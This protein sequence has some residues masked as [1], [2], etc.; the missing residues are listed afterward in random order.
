MS[1]TKICKICRLPKTLDE[2]YTYR[3]RT[4]NIE[5][6]RKICKTCYKLAGEQNNKERRRRERLKQT[7]K[8]V[9]FCGKIKLWTE[10]DNKCTLCR[11]CS[12]KG[13]LSQWIF[14]I[15]NRSKKKNWN[16][17]IDTNFIQELFNKQGGKCAITKIPFIF[18]SI[19]NKTPNKKDPFAPSLDRID[20]SKGYT[21]DN[22]RIVCIIVNYALNEF[23]YD[24]FAKMCKEFVTNTE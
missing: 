13:Y 3:T 15:K 10:F 4:R 2:F 6:H 18:N 5:K 14:N 20:S 17:D 12:G 23:G 24:V 16:Y 22:V 21:K 9:G 8:C 1:I 11:A 7:R 19:K